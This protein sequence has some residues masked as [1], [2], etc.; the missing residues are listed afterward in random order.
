MRVAYLVNQYPAVSHTFIR[1][2]IAALERQGFEV[3]RLSLRG[4]DK[5]LVDEDDRHERTLTRYVLK[6][7]GAV[8]LVALVRMAAGNPRGFWRA[9][10]LALRMSRGAER[11]L[12]VHLVYLA[13]AC[14]IAPWLR[15]AGVR[16]LHAHFGTNP[17]EVAML[18]G[19][20]GGQSWSFTVHGVETFDRW[21]FIGLDEKIRRAAFVVAVC[22]YG[23][24]VL[25]RSVHHQHWHKIKVVHCGLDAAFHDIP[26][27]P[28]TAR[29]LVCIGRICE[30]KGQLLLVEAARRLQQEGFEFEL[31]LGGDGEL[32][33]EI[34]GI[35]RRHGL[36]EHVRI[37]G[38]LDS[39]QVRHE[40]LEARALVL[41][42]FAEGLPVA[43]MEAMSLARPIISTYVGGI[44][45]LVRPS[46]EGWLVPAGDVDA[47]TEAMR[48]CLDI[49]IKTIVSMGERARA[50]VLARH[51]ID[52]EASK[53]GCLMNSC[54]D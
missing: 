1:R 37:T 16:H 53:L 13:E 34:E 51:D 15:A 38:W 49:P 8:L 52:E 18:V 40:I 47:L 48:S 46:E 50:R 20:L 26:R 14:R 39:N 5:E 2:E 32:R 3:T 12:P 25:Y 4:W 43:I 33:A 45:E 28:P 42:S 54:N 35:I 10:V 7:G 41:P 19:V 36:Q 29:R 21:P 6:G 44:P 24:G 30:E 23:R 11:P 17:A 27:R 22:S 9:L 31:V